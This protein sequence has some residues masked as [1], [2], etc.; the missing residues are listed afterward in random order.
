MY[1]SLLL[2]FIFCVDLVKLHHVHRYIVDMFSYPGPSGTLDSDGKQN[3]TYAG[4]R[5][6]S[7]VAFSISS[8][9]RTQ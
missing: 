2:A 6:V 3:T 8:H 5:G 9:E 4:A 1:F 7:I